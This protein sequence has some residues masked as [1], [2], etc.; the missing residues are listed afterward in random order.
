VEK[1]EVILVPTLRVG[2]SENDHQSHAGVRLPPKRPWCSARSL[3]E[4]GEEMGDIVEWYIRL[5]RN[6]VTRAS[7]GS[8][9][10]NRGESDLLE[11]A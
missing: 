8:A 11:S 9:E 3:E 1:A 7:A 4:T 10:A 5:G 6:V 2:T